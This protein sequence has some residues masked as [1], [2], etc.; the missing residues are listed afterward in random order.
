M[1]LVPPL[2]HRSVSTQQTG[3][4]FIGE[5]RPSLPDPL[6]AIVFFGVDDTSF[7]VYTPFYGGRYDKKS[8]GGFM[9]SLVN[10]QL[11][12]RVVI[13]DS[14]K[15][16]SKSISASGLSQG[17]FHAPRT[18]TPPNW[19]R[20]VSSPWIIFF[21]CICCA[22]FCLSSGMKYTPASYAVGDIMAF[23]FHSAF[24]VFNMVGIVGERH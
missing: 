24:W 6:K 21:V 7:T 20:A 22:A 9:S 2:T 13:V 10:L 19:L 14:S 1:T 3:F 17:S 4:S 12:S 16:H 8:P 15:F 5:S 11:P 18:R 23:D